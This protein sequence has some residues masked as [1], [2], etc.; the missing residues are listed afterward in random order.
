[1]FIDKIIF[2]LSDLCPL[3]LLNSCR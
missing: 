2:G 3:H 1:M